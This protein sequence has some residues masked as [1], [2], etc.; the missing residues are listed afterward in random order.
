MTWIA[1][2]LPYR[3]EE[4]ENWQQINLDGDGERENPA[5]NVLNLW[6]MDKARI[7]WSIGGGLAVLFD[8][9]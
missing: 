2:M 1:W 7:E 4:N 6:E 5:G 9:P 8:L 3:Q